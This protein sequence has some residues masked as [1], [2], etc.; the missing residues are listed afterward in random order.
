MKHSLILTLALA[1]SLALIG[2]P[3]TSTTQSESET[4]KDTPAT[5]SPEII[6]MVNLN[7]YSKDTFI[8]LVDSDID[9]IDLAVWY[10]GGSLIINGP[11]Y[12]PNETMEYRIPNNFPS[13]VTEIGITLLAHHRLIANMNNQDFLSTSRI[14][15]CSLSSIK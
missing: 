10:D 13:E 6:V 4:G 1:L 9:R 3:N 14:S 15:I 8:D 11:P 5:I 2:C 12:T 7:Y